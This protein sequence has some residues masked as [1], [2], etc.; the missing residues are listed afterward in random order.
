MNYTPHTWVTGETIDADELNN[1]EAGVGDAHD[2]L[3]NLDS[4]VAAAVADSVTPSATN[5]ALAFYRSRA[6]HTGT[7]AATTITGLASVALSGS[8]TDLTGRPSLATVATTGVY[9]DLTGKPS[10][11]TVATTGVYS[12]L[13][14]K[15]ALYTDQQVRTVVL[16]ALVDAGTVSITPDDPTTPTSITISSTVGLADLPSGST[17]AVHKAAGVWPG[18]PTS[19]TDLTGLWIGADPDPSADSSGTVFLDGVDLRFVTP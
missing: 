3:D 2:Q 18:R 13:T 17:F 6:N 12:D 9:S 1:I 19:R 15:P 7:Q 14:G 10:L 8:Y 16:A 5:T 4:T 11:A